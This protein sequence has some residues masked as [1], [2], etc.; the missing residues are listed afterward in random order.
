MDSGVGVQLNGK[1]ASRRRFDAKAPTDLAR[2]TP[3]TSTSGRLTLRN[4]SAHSELRLSLHGCEPKS[5]TSTRI[6]SFGSRGV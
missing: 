1:P 4:V 2:L 5:E 3:G 6:E